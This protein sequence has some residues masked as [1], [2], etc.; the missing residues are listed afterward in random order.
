MMANAD[1]HQRRGG[2]HLA[3][4]LFWLLGGLGMWALGILSYTHGNCSV[5]P[6]GALVRIPLPGWA[7][8]GIGIYGVCLGIS[9]F[10]PEKAAA[11][12]ETETGA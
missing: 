1:T 10:L 8:V 2:W 5:D 12:E 6:P 7:S 3:K 4:A 11:R 9:R